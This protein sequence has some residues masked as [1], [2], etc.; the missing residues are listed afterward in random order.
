TA[1]TNVSATTE[2]AAEASADLAGQELILYSGRNENLV[3][4]IIDEFE[5]A[6]GAVV[7]VRY[8]SSAE[9]VAALLEEGERT[10]A[11]V[12]FSQEVGAVGALAK[13]GML[14]PLPD[15]VIGRVD[16]RF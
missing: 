5:A 16:E 3:Q 7:K 6:T 10:P 15:E 13:A 2:P 9:V 14:A 8:G 11:E 12:F 1:V 4:P